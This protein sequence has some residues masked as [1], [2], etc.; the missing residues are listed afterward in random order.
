MAATNPV[1]E[2]FIL[3]RLLIVPCA[4]RSLKFDGAPSALLNG[5]PSALLNGAPPA[6][7]SPDTMADAE[8]HYLAWDLAETHRRKKRHVK[9]R[10]R[11]NT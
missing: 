8:A 6:L 10:T 11:A 7:P 1:R 3:R 2:S 4:R 9:V 5:A